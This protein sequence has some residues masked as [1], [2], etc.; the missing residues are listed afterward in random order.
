MTRR[1]LNLIVLAIA[2]PILSQD[3]KAQDGLDPL[4][5]STQALN[6]SASDGPVSP[7][8]SL[9]PSVAKAN[10]FSTFLDNPAAVALLDK[11]FFSFG[12]NNNNNNNQTNFLGNSNSTDRNQGLLTDIGFVYKSPTSRGSLVFGAG[13]SQQNNFN[14]R[15][16]FL[17][18]NSS[19]TITDQFRLDGRQGIAFDVFATD[20]G[21]DAGTFIESIFRIGFAPGEF[22]GISQTVDISQSGY[23]GEFSGFIGTEFQEN[24]YVGAS[25]GITTGRLSFERTF[26][27]SDINGDYNDAFIDAD[28]DGTPETDIDRLVFRDDNTT[29]IRGTTLRIGTLYTFDRKVNIGASYQF[30]S[31]LDIEEDFFTSAQTTFDN[32]NRLESDDSGIFEYDILRPARLSLGVAVEDLGG[33]SI[34]GAVDFIDYANT[35]VDFSASEGSIAEQIFINNEEIRPNFQDVIN[36]RVGAEYDVTQNFILR[37]GYSYLPARTN[38]FVV[39]RSVLG[40]GGTFKLNDSVFFDISAQYSSFDDRSILYTFE[41]FS[42]QFVDET[43]DENIEVINVLAGIRLIF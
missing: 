30:R 18:F 29:E 3:L 35:E 26:I 43:L 15:S 9:I 37:G 13:Y 5:F 17:G 10:G 22:P 34:S 14:R 2:L 6:I 36:Y 8:G 27:E 24:F 41:D 42:G 21:D 7:L 20:F 40:L 38:Q 1:V 32:G 16:S 4:L 19:S 33:F 25:L 23:V 12:Y 28:E 31:R 11:G 39:D